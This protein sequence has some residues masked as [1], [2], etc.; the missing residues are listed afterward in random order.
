MHMATK[1]PL[2]SARNQKSILNRIIKAEAKNLGFSLFGI[3]S[4]DPPDHFSTFEEWLESGSQADMGYL[5]RSDAVARR[6]EPHLLK[7]ECTSILCLGFPY[8]NANSL[9]AAGEGLVGRIASYALGQDYHLD[10][11][12]RMD[13]LMERVEKRLERKIAY[14]VFT[15]SAPIL[16][17]DLAHRAGLGWIGKNSCL[18]HPSCGSYFFLAEI[19]TDL[20]LEADAP[21]IFDRCGSCTR[22]IEACPTQC[23]QSNRTIDSRRC[24]S[25]LT[26]ENKRLIP[27]ELR[28]NVGKWIFGCD[29]CQMVCPWNRTRTAAEEKEKIAIQQDNSGGLKNLIEEMALTDEEFKQKY[30]NSPVLRA[31]RKGYLR[32][33]AVALGNTRNSEAIPVLIKA[34]KTDGEPLIRS[35]SAWALGQIG[36]EVSHFALRQAMS[37]EGDSLVLDEIHAILG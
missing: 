11:P 6:R 5:S 34:L 10:L 28:H 8:S 36:S 19:F 2:V 35:H 21:F 25:Y 33:V 15:D 12:A 22:C 17:R 26:I 37:T 13:D 7:P 9:P 29:V 20:E 14:K 30:A 24:I 1:N 27:R 16:E 18:I 3:T 4:P 32:N 31:K 23:I